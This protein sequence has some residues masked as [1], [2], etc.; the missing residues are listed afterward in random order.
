MAGRARGVCHDTQL[1]CR[2]AATCLSTTTRSPAASQLTGQRREIAEDFCNARQTQCQPL[3]VKRPQLRVNHHMPSG[4]HLGINCVG[5]PLECPTYHQRMGGSLCC[6]PSL[7]LP[8][9]APGA[10]RWSSLIVAGGA[11]LPMCDMKSASGGASNVLRRGD[12][13]GDSVS[14]QIQGRNFAHAHGKHKC[15]AVIQPERPRITLKCPDPT[16]S[17][18]KRL[19]H[20]PPPP[21][22]VPPA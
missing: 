12:C 15:C 5:Q 21:P 3:P 4:S 13:F 7:T 1:P 6:T 11:P 14:A 8:P 10:I 2:T 19:R 18:H 9:P 16:E 20:P 22:H 17:R